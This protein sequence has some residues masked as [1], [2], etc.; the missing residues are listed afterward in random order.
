[1]RTVILLLVTKHL[2]LLYDNFVLELTMPACFIHSGSTFCRTHVP[3]T[4]TPASPLPDP[5]AVIR[6][7]RLPESGQ[8][9]AQEPRSSHFTPSSL[10]C[11]QISGSQGAGDFALCL[12]SC[13]VPRG[14]CVLSQLHFSKQSNT[15][16]REGRDATLHRTK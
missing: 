14:S 15:W 11:G 3:E 2:P 4:V 10:V 16:L 8:A 5:T 13:L 1:M 6:Q 12:A 9:G 7:P